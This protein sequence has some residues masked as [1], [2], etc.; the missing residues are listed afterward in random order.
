MS[1]V[2]YFIHTADFGAYYLGSTGKVKT[3]RKHHFAALRSGKHHCQPLQRTFAKHGEDALIFS[4]AAMTETRQAASELE[5]ELLAFHFRKPGCLNVSSNGLMPAQCPD[6][7]ARRNVTLKGQAHRAKA[8]E[9]AKAWRA[10]NPDL[11]AAADA[12]SAA[13]RR[14]SPA[15]SA[16][17]AERVRARNSTPEAVEAFKKRM[18]RHRRTGAPNGFAK[19]VIRIGGDG[20]EVRFGSAAEAARATPTAHFGSISRCCL[21]QGKS[22]GGYGWRFA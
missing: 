6:V 11:A 10:A 18:E 7:V 19:A 16:A 3:R 14:S 21:G 8:S 20:T 5:H 17:N 12:K 9:A 15:W 13:T 22:S 4:I 1:G 2:V